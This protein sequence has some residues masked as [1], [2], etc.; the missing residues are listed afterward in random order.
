M[1]HW[2]KTWLQWCEVF[3]HKVKTL[4]ATQPWRDL[5]LGS[6]QSS[7]H[8]EHHDGAIFARIASSRDLIHIIQHHQ[9]QKPPMPQKSVVMKWTLSYPIASTS[10]MLNTILH[11]VIKT[12]WSSWMLSVIQFW[13]EQNWNDLLW[14]NPWQHWKQ[15]VLK[16]F[17]KF[18]IHHSVVGSFHHFWMRTNNT[19][20]QTHW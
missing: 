2:T 4:I 1:L 10:N 15:N 8:R 16:R 20:E 7:K 13:S 3:Y 11:K 17:S 19:A 5:H 18:M 6:D 14:T 9:Q 12:R